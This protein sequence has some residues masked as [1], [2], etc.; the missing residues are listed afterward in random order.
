VRIKFYLTSS[1]RSPVQVFLEG[2]SQ[3]VKQN[4][5]DAISLLAQGQNLSMPLSRPL[6]SIYQGLHELRF[7]DRA[8]Q[9]RIFYFLKKQ[10]GIYLLHA[11]RKKTQELPQKEV[12]LILKRI[13]EI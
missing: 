4:F 8:G 5:F 12:D 13:R 3:E 2:V 10:E 9:V 6:S 1:G 11:F 7:K